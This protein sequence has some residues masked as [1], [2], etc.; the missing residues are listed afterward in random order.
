[1]RFKKVKLKNFEAMGGTWEPL[2]LT[3]K[4]GR[5]EAKFCRLHLDGYTAKAKIHFYD[6]DNFFRMPL[7]DEEGWEVDADEY[8]TSVL[9]EKECYL[10]LL[11]DEYEECEKVKRKNDRKKLWSDF[12][13]HIVLSAVF[14]LVTLFLCCLHYLDS[15]QR[16]LTWLLYSAIC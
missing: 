13:I 16:T 12:K 3:E 7:L 14:C 10:P 9:L 1:M 2:L 5:D 15:V 8:I 11:K 6:G 4:M